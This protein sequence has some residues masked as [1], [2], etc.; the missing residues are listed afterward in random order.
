[1]TCLNKLD[2]VALFLKD[3][4]PVSSPTD[5]DTH[6]ISHDNFIDFDHTYKIRPFFTAISYFFFLQDD[7]PTTL[8]T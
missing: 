4:P 5:A 1:M 6:P 2:G 3:P 8:V 7:G